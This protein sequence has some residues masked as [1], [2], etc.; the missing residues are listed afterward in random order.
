MSKEDHFKA[1]LKMI[2]VTPDNYKSLT[3]EMITHICRVVVD[4]EQLC[5]ASTYEGLS[6]AQIKE[7][8][9]P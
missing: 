3:A 2:H 9:I 5:K 4:A 8:L 6:A 7:K 1:A